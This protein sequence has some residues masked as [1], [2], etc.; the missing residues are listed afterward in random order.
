MKLVVTH[1]KGY[2]D[3]F[4]RF[5]AEIDKIVEDYIVDVGVLY[6]KITYLLSIDEEEADILGFSLDRPEGIHWEITY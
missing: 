2:D 4:R 6:M 3:N 5:I 1:N